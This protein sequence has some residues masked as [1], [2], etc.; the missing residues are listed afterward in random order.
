MVLVLSDGVPGH[1][2]SSLGVVA[3]L[4]DRHD[5]AT[6]WLRI[7]ENKPRSRRMARVA[8]ALSEPERWLAKGVSLGPNI[9]ADGIG[10]EGVLHDWP[11]RA[12]I[13]VSTGPSTAAANIAAARRYGARNI[14]CGFPKR[15]VLGY[16]LI[17]SPVPSRSASVA[18]TAR[19]SEI[20]AENLL[21]PREL[22][23]DEDRTVAVLF[24]GESKHYSYTAQDM[25]TLADSLRAVLQDA[26]TWECHVYDSR[27][28]NDRTFA[29]FATAVADEP[30]I[31][32]H[33]FVDGGLGSNS[34]AFDADAV[35]VTADSLSMM[36]E[37]LAAGRPTHVVRAETYRGPPRD[38]GEIARLS[39][40]GLVA[41]STF[42]DFTLEGLMATPTP[43]RVSRVAELSALLAQ[44]GF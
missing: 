43:P 18:L 13:V 38:Q 35:I 15:P 2:R 34:A 24:G 4:K 21:E 44:R 30:R 11:P 16:S 1:D 23:R 12:D 7:S 25:E 3:A 31:A 28:T 22:A 37:A 14:Y 32:L 19:P 20:N 26:A 36:T 39:A 42:A 8:A 29:A 41:R 17:L 9:A 33:R 40:D 5:L 27:R 10:G 6:N